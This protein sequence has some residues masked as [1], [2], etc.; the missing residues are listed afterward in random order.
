M[1]P[2]IIG[3]DLLSK[4]AQGNFQIQIATVFPHQNVVVTLPGNH[5]H[6]VREY[7]TIHNA[8][9]R[10]AGQVDLTDR[11][12]WDLM[13]AAVDLLIEGRTVLIRPNPANMKL[14]FEADDVLQ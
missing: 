11:E 4:D 10:Q 8:E 12:R 9:R 1:K 14:A 6:Q 13:D 2:R 5:A 7:L 3:P